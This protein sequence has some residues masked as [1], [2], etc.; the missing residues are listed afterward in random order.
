MS[1][2]ARSRIATPPAR[3]VHVLLAVAGIVAIGWNL[4]DTLD[5]PDGDVVNFFSFFTIQSNLFAAAV[6]LW[7]AARP[8][9]SPL[10]DRLRGA[11]TLFLL[12]TGIIYAVLLSGE[13]SDTAA[14]INDIEHRILPVAILVDWLV[15]APASP[16]RAVSALWWLLYPLAFFAYSLVRGAIVD[17]YP[18]P[19]MSPLV[20]PYGTVVLTAAILAVLMG[21]LA[22][23]VAALGSLRSPGRTAAA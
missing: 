16:V 23:L 11:A 13:T 22:A 4:H 3:L 10:Q 20:H 9:P 1:S 15:V 2:T 6:W 5:R 7:V 14:W 8:S 12:I 19:F 21:L 18:Y 17:W